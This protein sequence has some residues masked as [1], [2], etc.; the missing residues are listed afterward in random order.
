MHRTP[1]SVFVN[2]KFYSKQRD[3]WALKNE[4]HFLKDPITCCS[5]VLDDFN[6]DGLNDLTYKSA[7]AARGQMTSDSYSFMT[8][9]VMNSS[10]LRI[11]INIQIFVIMKSW[12][13]LT[14]F[15]YMVIL[16]LFKEWEVII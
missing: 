10:L 8:K 16:L 4:F 12:I 14:H 15:W 6:H 5:P 7:I 9:K 13:A 3:A 11:Q 2:I 1:D